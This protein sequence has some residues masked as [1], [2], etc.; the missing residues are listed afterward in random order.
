MKRCALLLLVVLIA[1]PAAAQ[2]KKKDEK[3]GKEAQAP[4][5]VDPVKDAEAKLAA[6][7][8][9]GAISVLEGVKATNGAAALMLGVLRETQAHEKLEAHTLRYQVPVPQ[10]GAAKVT[11]RVRVRF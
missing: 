5:V 9:D 3:K 4:A 8:A 1:V 7:D 6:G 10:E 2:D 11:Y